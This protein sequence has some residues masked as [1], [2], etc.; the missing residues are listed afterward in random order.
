MKKVDV[1]VLDEII[2]QGG[3]GCSC[4]PESST[5]SYSIKSMLNEFNEN[6]P[7][8]GEYSILD[9]NQ[10]K[11]E[12]YLNTLNKVLKS[13]GE[14]LVINDDNYN[15]VL[16]KILPMVVVNGKIV[17]I[18]SLPVGDDMY[19]AIASESKIAKASGCC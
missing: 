14:K 7:S 17:A 2:Q 1:Y 10:N 8:L 4:S 5:D 12:Q 19:N 9:W 11:N 3:C 15:F 16:P 6:H 13:N 18:N